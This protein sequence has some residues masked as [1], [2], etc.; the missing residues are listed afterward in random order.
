MA[1]LNNIDLISPT[2]IGEDTF[3]V[4]FGDPDAP[5]VANQPIEIV[6][7]YDEAGQDGIVL[8][9]EL[10]V[11]PRTFGGDG[12][13]YQRK[14]YRRTA[15]ETLWLIFP[16]AGQ[17]LILLR[18]MYHNEWQGRFMAEIEGDGFQLVTLNTRR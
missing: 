6:V 9:L 12:A 15:P 1:T 4:A 11:Q 5:K 7:D 18:E 2:F 14:V 8:P 3:T 16:W 13:G 10:I 17:Y